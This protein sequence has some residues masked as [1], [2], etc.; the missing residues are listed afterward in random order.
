MAFAK[1]TR[2]KAICDRC[3]LK[4]KYSQLVLE[5]ENSRPNGLKVCPSCLDEDHPQLK[6]GKTRI[7]DAQALR[8]PRPD[9]AET[10]SNNT[11]F[12]SRFPHTAGVTS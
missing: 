10:A 12:N 6:L 8:D 4:Y 7:V 3:G 9:R 11:A 1:G 2:S 5:I